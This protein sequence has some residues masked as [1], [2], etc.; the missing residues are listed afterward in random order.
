MMYVYDG[1]RDG[2]DYEKLLQFMKMFLWKIA[3]KSVA[4]AAVARR[5]MAI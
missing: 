2:D 3:F 5:I 1:D 4:T